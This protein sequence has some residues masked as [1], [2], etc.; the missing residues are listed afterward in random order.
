MKRL[1]FVVLCLVLFCWPVCADTVDYS[2]EYVS[3]P[4]DDAGYYTIYRLFDADNSSCQYI[5]TYIEY[6]D[7]N[8]AFYYYAII[9]SWPANTYPG[10]IESALKDQDENDDFAVLAYNDERIVCAHLNPDAGD[11]PPDIH[12]KLCSTI[13]SAS[14]EDTFLLA[15]FP[16]DL[17]TSDLVVKVRLSDQAVSYAEEAIRILKGYMDFS[18]PADEALKLINALQ[19]RVESFID[20]DESCPTDSHV[21]SDLFLT[22]LYISLKDDSSILE[23]IAKLEKLLP[24]AVEIES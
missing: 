8:E 13:G 10:G 4:Y 15:D 14:C 11:Y 7:D 19:D 6:P 5:L 21:K 17:M 9:S 24:D 16:E 22:D 3:F 23:R 12:E 2:D 18:I 1:C 20:S